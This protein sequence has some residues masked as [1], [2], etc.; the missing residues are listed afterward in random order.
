[1]AAIIDLEVRHRAGEFGPAEDL[2]T[3]GIQLVIPG[4][5][6]VQPASVKQGELF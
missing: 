1:M 5:E 6:R 3:E 2:T 4:A